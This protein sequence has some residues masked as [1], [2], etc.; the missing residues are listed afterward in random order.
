M[1]FHLLANFV[2]LAA[3]ANTD[4]PAL[5]DQVMPRT[6]NHFFPPKPLLCLAAYASAVTLVRARINTPKSRQFGFKYIEPINAA[7]LP[8]SNPNMMFMFDEPFRFEKEEEIALELTDSAAGPNDAYGLF[9]VTD[10]LEPIVK[11][12]TYYIRAT[13]TTTVTASAWSLLTTTYD[14]NL[15]MGQYDVVNLKVESTNCISARLIFVDQI[16]R[17]GVI[18]TASSGQRQPDMFTGYRMGRFGT[19]RTNALP[20]VEVL[21]DAADATFTIYMEVIRRGP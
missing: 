8:G 6:N 20:Q 13:S 14:F 17:P 19:F 21:C 16:W 7:L 5:A 9:W 15:P 2:S 3:T 4:T 11:G 18:G 1:A 12:D 10:G